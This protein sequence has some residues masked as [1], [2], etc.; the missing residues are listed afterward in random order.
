MILILLTEV[1]VLHVG[2]TAVDVRGFGLELV[3]RSTFR[4]LEKCLEEVIHVLLRVSGNVRS[5]GSRK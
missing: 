1:I 2:P 4:D 3:P 5:R